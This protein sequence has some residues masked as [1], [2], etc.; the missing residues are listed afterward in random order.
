MVTAA[1]EQRKQEAH[2]TGRNIAMSRSLVIKP[3][4]LI[5]QLI[6]TSFSSK[7]TT[8]GL[9][10]LKETRG[11]SGHS[12]SGTK[13]IIPPGSSVTLSPLARI[14]SFSSN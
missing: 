4:G 5:G 11:I 14:K 1:P 7:T 3:A 9:H 10:Q 6:Y 8:N 2:K 12:K 13:P